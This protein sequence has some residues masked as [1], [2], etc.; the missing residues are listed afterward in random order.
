M[1]ARAS[2]ITD[3]GARW[4][5]SSWKGL[6]QPSHPWDTESRSIAKWQK[7]GWE[8]V[9]QSAATLHTTLNFRR[10]KRKVPWIP[11]AG[12]VLV[13]AIIGGVVG[14]LASKGS[15]SNA[16]PVASQTPSATLTPTPEASASGE[17]AILTARNSKEFAVLLALRDNC[18]DS[19]APFAAKD[20]DRTIEFDGS[21]ADVAKYE[22]GYDILIAPGDKGPQSGIGPGFKYAGVSMRDL[23]ITGADA[24]AVGDLVHVVARVGEY[25]QTQCL[26]FLE[27]TSTRIR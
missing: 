10:V 4:K 6:C 27:P 21:V 9:D 20:Q 18:D 22:I 23:N 15:S 19:I 14:V 16:G 11:I 13:L 1:P 2:W 12:A 26:F 7:D 24:V 3:I 25:N 17:P 8:L 5:C